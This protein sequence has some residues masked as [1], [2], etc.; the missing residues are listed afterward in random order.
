MLRAGRRPTRIPSTAG[1]RAASSPRSFGT[2]ASGAGFHSATTVDEDP[3]RDRRAVGRRLARVYGASWFR[4]FCGVSTSTSRFVCE[5]VEAQRSRPGRVVTCA[6]LLSGLLCYD[7]R[8]RD[9]ASALQSAWFDEAP[10]S[11]PLH[12]MPTFDIEETTGRE[13]A[14]RPGAPGR[15]PKGC[16]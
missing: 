2:A 4:W 14:R 5:G 1:R 11:A 16:L 13:G 15:P 9:T 12:G 10:R 3:G 7:P 6:G 8:R